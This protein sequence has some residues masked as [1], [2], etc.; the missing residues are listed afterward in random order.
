MQYKLNEIINLVYLPGPRNGSEIVIESN[1][2]YL[3]VIAG[4]ALNKV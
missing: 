2:M 3:L 1:R 4:Q